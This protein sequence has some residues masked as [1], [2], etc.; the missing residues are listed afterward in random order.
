M[1][2]RLA[3]LIKILQMNSVKSRLKAYRLSFFYKA[4]NTPIIDDTFAVEKQ[5]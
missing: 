3:T 5:F 2:Y 4:V 1:Q